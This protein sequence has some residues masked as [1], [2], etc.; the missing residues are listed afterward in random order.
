MGMQR[1]ATIDASGKDAKKCVNTGYLYNVPD[2][3]IFNSFSKT[4][5]LQE[6]ILIF[7]TPRADL[8]ALQIILHAS[9]AFP[10]GFVDLRGLQLSRPISIIYFSP[11]LPSRSKAFHKAIQGPK[12]TLF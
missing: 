4:F 7:S 12:R 8:N 6:L 5:L 9:L 1:M 10:V 11:V 2:A 3:H